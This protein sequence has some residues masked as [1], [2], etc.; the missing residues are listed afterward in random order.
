MSERYV[1]HAIPTVD[2]NGYAKNVSCMILRRIK[3]G[4]TNCNARGTRRKLSIC[5]A[6]QI[7]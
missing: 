7:I 2:A 4:L 1:F 5:T 3:R 6:G